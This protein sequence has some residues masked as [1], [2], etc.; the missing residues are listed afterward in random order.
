MTTIDYAIVGCGAMA[1]T[2]AQAAAKNPGSSVRYCV[3]TDLSRAEQFAQ[4]YGGIGTDN[5][6][7]A[8]ADPG[9][10]AVA[11][12]LP[13]HLH[14]E[15]SVKAAEAG[16]HIF[17]EKP[18]ACTVEECDRMMAA[19]RAAGVQLFV[20]HVLRFWEANI[21]IKEMIQS[22]TLGRP[23]LARYYSEGR[24]SLAEDRMHLID[25]AKGGGV[26]LAGEVHHTDLIRWWM[27]EVK[28]VRGYHLNLRPEFANCDSQ[29]F[30]MV[31][32]EFEDGSIGE[33]S[34]SYATLSSPALNLSKSVVQFEKG[35]VSVS[36]EGVMRILREGSSEVEEICTD[37]SKAAP[38]EIPHFTS[39]IQNGTPLVCTP[40]DARR[41]VELCVAAEESA[42]LG[43]DVDLQ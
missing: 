35:T 43:H 13:H 25:P 2:H 6:E 37:P 3:D 1:R 39:A 12:V 14:C 31:V 41:A 8:L 28:R 4:Q 36:S 11:I 17:V 34:Y 23:F 20:A 27:G 32:Y 19:A 22:R 40:E 18:M 7:V 10:H 29:E 24:P 38:Q 42:H 5:Y 15:F 30:S 9:V 26:I 33:T 16:K 21:R